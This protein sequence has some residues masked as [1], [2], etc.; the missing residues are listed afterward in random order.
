MWVGDEREKAETSQSELCDKQFKIRAKADI[1]VGAQQRHY[2]KRSLK[3]FDSTNASSERAKMSEFDKQGRPWVP[4]C[5]AC[6]AQK[7]GPNY[8]VRCSPQINGDA[9]KS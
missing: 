9:C 5:Y 6:V 7:G 4:W 3:T 8:N 2:T 1:A